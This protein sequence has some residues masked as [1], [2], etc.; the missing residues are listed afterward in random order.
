MWLAS[1]YD[2]LNLLCNLHLI[3]FHVDNKGI[4]IE[5]AIMEDSYFPVSNVSNS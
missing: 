5:N 4:F 3:L 2:M 1:V